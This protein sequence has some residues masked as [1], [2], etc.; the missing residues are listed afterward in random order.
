MR[1][2]IRYAVSLLLCVLTLSCERQDILMECFCNNRAKVPITIDW[3]KS[4]IIPQNITILFYNDRDGSL[5]L[6]H[7]YEHNT[8]T[9]H[10]YVHLPVGEYTAVAF[11][12]L[13]NQINNVS[14]QE[15]ENLSTLGFYASENVDVV[16]RSRSHTYAHQPGMLGVKI[17]KNLVVTNELIDYTYDKTLTRISNDTKS[18]YNA[19]LNIIPENK[20]SWLN[21]N[22]DVKGL[23]NARMPALVDLKNISVGYMAGDDKNCHTPAVMQFDINNRTY[24]PGSTTDGTISTR[25]ALFGTLGDRNSITDHHDKPIIVDILFMLVDKDKTLIRRKKDI[26]NLITFNKE[27]SGSISLIVDVS[28]DTPL[29]DVKPEGGSDSGFGSELEDWGNVDVPLS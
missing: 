10:S 2:L 7:C 24:N 1:K 29:P 27:Q 23:I 6:E 4:G 8:N 28:I 11:N 16:M 14:V 20:I 26:T 12:E 25:V 21:I 13:R 22:V 9:V 3:T 18:R 17:I 19:L 5:V 15:Y